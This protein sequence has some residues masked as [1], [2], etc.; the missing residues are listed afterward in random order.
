VISDSH[1]SLKKAVR[2]VFSAAWQRCSVRFMHNALASVGGVATLMNEARDDVLAYMSFRKSHWSQIR[3]TN[4][5]P[6]QNRLA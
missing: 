5:V 6:I 1:E 3:S 4:P 2:K